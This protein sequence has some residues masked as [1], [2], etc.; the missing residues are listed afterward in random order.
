VGLAGLVVVG[1]AARVP[2]EEGQTQV[3]VRRDVVVHP[4]Q[5]PRRVGIYL[6]VSVSFA[7]RASYIQVEL[8]AD[9][10]IR[11]R[12]AGPV[13]QTMVEKYEVFVFDVGKGNPV[14]LEAQADVVTRAVVHGP[15][16]AV[17]VALP[18]DPRRSVAPV[19]LATHQQFRVRR[20]VRVEVGVRP[21]R[22][23]D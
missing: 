15:C 8:P 1:G 19:G 6:V 12:F 13:P 16:P 20:R 7:D 5:S 10:Q 11:Y 23:R 17:Q 3:W 2:A 22:K 21:R 9:V 4:D 18:L 14:A